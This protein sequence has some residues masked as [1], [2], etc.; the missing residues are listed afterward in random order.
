VLPTFHK[1]S[2]KQV[3]VKPLTLNPALSILNPRCAVLPTFHKVSREQA[4]L[5]HQTPN[6]KPLTLNPKSCTQHPIFGPS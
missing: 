1:V 4:A 6:P 2:R 5:K 3:A